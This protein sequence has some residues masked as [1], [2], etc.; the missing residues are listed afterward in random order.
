MWECMEGNSSFY[1]SVRGNLGLILL[2]VDSITLILFLA[3]LLRY[4]HA[5][6]SQT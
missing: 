2:V 5:I 6:N 4:M 1:T 3:D